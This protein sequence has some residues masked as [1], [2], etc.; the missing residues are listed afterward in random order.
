MKNVMLVLAL[1]L[2]LAITGCQTGTYYP[3]ADRVQSFINLLNS[4]YSYDSQ[5]YLVKHPSQTATEG[6]VVVYSNDTGWVA[7]DIANY[8]TGDS[9]YTYSANAQ[10]QEVYVYD[11]YTDYYGEV[12]YVGGAYYNDYWGSY[13]GEFI[14]EQTED[15]FKDLEKIA[16]L[17]ASFKTAKLGE[18][19]ASDYGLS[20]ERATKVAKLVTEW[21]KTGKKRAL[22]ESDA[23]AF[24]KE[25]LGVNLN[26]AEKAYK[27]LVEGDKQSFQDLMATAAKTNGTTP[28]Q[29]NS[30][31]NEFMNQ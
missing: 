13:A 10:F 11:S 17:K 3:P 9:W 19:F 14:F 7:Y 29:M 12:F 20:V 15:A 30:I 27:K 31:V 2:G 18:A 22:T 24:T 5:F 28:E 6:F 21:E 23:N 26:D 4:Q 16:A 8:Q 1:L 25:L